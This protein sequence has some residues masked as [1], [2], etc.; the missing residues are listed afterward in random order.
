M[1]RRGVVEKSRGLQAGRTD[2]KITPGLVSCGSVAPWLR[3]CAAAPS[4]Q[5]TKPSRRAGRSGPGRLGPRPGIGLGVK[6]GVVAQLGAG[7]EVGGWETL[8]CRSWLEAGCP[9]AGGVCLC[10]GRL[11]APEDATQAGR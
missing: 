10:G 1:E 7:C 2:E 4:R 6:P 9:D 3:G 5:T 8:G 11:D